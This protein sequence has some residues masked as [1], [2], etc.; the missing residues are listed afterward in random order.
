MI[1]LDKSRLDRHV[2]SAVNE[3]RMSTMARQF[4]A[5]YGPLIEEILAEI[6]SDDLIEDILVSVAR[7]AESVAAAEA[8][9]AEARAAAKA[10][11]GPRG[12]EALTA[13]R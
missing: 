8:R 4:T 10:E 13:T 6:D 3:D 5:G 11:D 12:Y 2:G 1:L 9:E 7:N